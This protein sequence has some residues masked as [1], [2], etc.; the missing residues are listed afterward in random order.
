M[1]TASPLEV[2]IQNVSG[3]E[4]IFLEVLSV[5]TL[6][7]APNFDVQYHRESYSSCYRLNSAPQAWGDN[8]TV[9]ST[10]FNRTW[11]FDFGGEP[12]SYSTHEIRVKASPTLTDQQGNTLV[13]DFVTRIYV[14]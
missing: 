8:V 10:V 1:V 11:V 2:G 14:Y 12:T 3:S 4:F 13:E 5:I 9:G 7:P 6:N